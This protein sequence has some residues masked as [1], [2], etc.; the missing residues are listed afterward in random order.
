MNFVPV[1]VGLKL[2]VSREWGLRPFEPLIGSPADE[3]EKPGYGIRLRAPLSSASRIARVRSGRALGEEALTIKRSASPA[4]R[5][6]LISE[7]PRGFDS[8]WP[9]W[10][11]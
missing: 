7:L 4:E 1:A 6:R 2:F 8:T 3:L 5:L 11:P 9:T 10:R